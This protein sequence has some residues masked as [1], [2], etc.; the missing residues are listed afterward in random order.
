M[1]VNLRPPLSLARQLRWRA[2][3]KVLLLV[4]SL[5]R[6]VTALFAEPHP[7]VAL[8]RYFHSHLYCLLV[9]NWSVL[10]VCD[11]LAGV[12]LVLVNDEHH[13]M[14]VLVLEEDKLFEEL[15][16]ET[17]VSIQ[18]WSSQQLKALLLL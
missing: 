9:P 12:P 18:H 13:H 7:Q 10:V 11:V 16:A 5:S 17:G 15:A 14:G 6:A 1:R 8:R 4:P 2:Q 3:Q